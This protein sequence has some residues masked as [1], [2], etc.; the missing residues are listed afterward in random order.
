MGLPKEKTQISPMQLTFLIIT[1]LISTADI[2]LPSFVAGE[3]EQ[4]SWLSPILSTA[5][6]LPIV[7]MHLNIYRRFQEMTLIEICKKA[8]GK[9]FGV[10]FGLSFVFYF[11]LI[12][13]SVTTEVALVMNTAFMPLTPPWMFIAPAILISAYAV[14]KDIEDI[15]RLNEILLPVG[16]G[17]IVVL[18]LTNIGEIDLNFFRPVLKDGMVPPLLGGLVIMGWMGEIIVILQIIPSVNKPLKINRAVYSGVL[19]TG[20]GI[21]VGSFIYALFGPLTAAFQMPALEFARFASVGR[22]VRNLDLFVMAIWITG[23]YVKIMVFY[24]ASTFA[25][26]QLFRVKDYKTL[27]LPVGLFLGIMSGATQGRAIENAQFLHY[28]FPLYS[29]TMSLVVPGI[30]MLLSLVKKERK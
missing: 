21:L 30:I 3:A 10:V 20:M 2:F 11:M 17:L 12:V 5:I 22:Y 19:V 28:I 6:T 24:Y 9:I 4:D 8:A 16:I 7:W 23:I 29:L 14:G 18:T 15:A 26:A 1:L 13:W 27:I 25:L